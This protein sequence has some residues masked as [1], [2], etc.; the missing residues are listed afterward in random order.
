MMV[1][2]NSSYNVSDANVEDN[3]DKNQPRH[4]CPCCKYDCSNTNCISCDYCNNWF[5]QECAKISDKR[6][7]S[8]STSSNKTF[9]CKFCASK[10]HKKCSQ[11]MILL[12]NTR[13]SNKNLYCISCKDWFC[14]DCL[15]LPPD[16]L[17]KFLSSDLPYFC[18]ECSI[19]FYCPI[20]LEL[21]R[22]KCIYCTCCARF[23]HMKCAKRPRGRGRDQN[24]ICQ[25]CIK[26]HLPVSA[27]VSTSDTAKS[28]E[29]PQFCCPSNT[30]LVNDKGCGLCIECNNDCLVC[31]V[32][33]DL[34]RVCDICLSCKNY[35]V[36]S[37]SKLFKAIERDNNISVLHVNADSLPCNFEKLENLMIR[38]NVYPDIIA[39]SETR[40]N[41]DH[42]LNLIQI[43]EYHKFIYKHT[44][45]T[46]SDYGGVGMYVS[47]KLHF[48][49]RTDLDFNFEGCETKFI[50]LPRKKRD[51][52]SV[53][54]GVI[55]RHE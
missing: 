43:P 32:C 35:D 13:L 40:L 33:P 55:Y 16:L 9:K 52:Q 3:H 8:L 17:D 29:A 37:F 30:N 42:N 19:D 50:E 7:L 47:N 44:N 10:K 4:P 21:C 27:V 49:H 11:C 6:F 31:D 34:Q 22:D 45:S 26:E 12:P 38:S 2:D 14:H 28:V 25:I 41:D 51:K 15:S 54:I 18:K 48:I 5:H 23:L 20:C 46:N 53:I 1:A 36:D 39:I 24:Y